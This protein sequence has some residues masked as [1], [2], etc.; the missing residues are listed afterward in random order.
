LCVGAIYFAYFSNKSQ[1]NLHKIRQATTMA[2]YQETGRRGGE[3]KNDLGNFDF[4]TA[5]IIIKDAII[6]SRYQAAKLVNKELLS[7]YYG[8]GKYVSDNS[9]GGFWGQGAIKQISETLQ[10]ELRGL[11]GFSEGSLKKMRLF[12]EEWSA[13]FLNRS[14]TTNDFD[15]LQIMELP[16]GENNA[17]LAVTPFGVGMDIDLGLLSRHIGGFVSPGFIADD[18]LRVG[19]THH[20]TIIAQEKSLTGRFFYISRCAAEFWSVEALKSYL[21]GDLHAKSGTLSN[22]FLQTL[23]EQEQARRAIRA[24]KDEYI[25]DFINIEDENDPDERLIERRIV[26]NIKQF[27]LTF[28]NKFCFIGNQY[29]VVVDEKEYFIDLLFFNREL[30]CLV[31]VELKRSEFKPSQLGQL[32]F[33]LSALDEYVRQPDEAPSIG[34]ILCKEAS[35]NTV[36]FAVRDYTKPMG[37]ATYRTRNEMPKQWQKALPD[38]EDMKKL[39]DSVGAEQ[40]REAG[41]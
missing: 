11:R 24:F 3:I 14:L 32:F 28:G 31:A 10:R 21:R 13:V 12:Y 25:L 22:N 15:H 41:E 37:V 40:E 9:R 26:A 29:R 20:Y 23:P 35:R 36:E 30:H 38:F 39:L 17:A 27:I 4:K 33:Y 19:F 18:F 7:L 5:A 8:V 1:K 2:R 16:S 34:I 6:R